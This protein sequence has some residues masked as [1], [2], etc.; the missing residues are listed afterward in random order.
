M[1]KRSEFHRVCKVREV[2]VIG[3]D[4]HGKTKSQESSQKGC[5][6]NASEGS[7]E[8]GR[9]KKGQGQSSHENAKNDVR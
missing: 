9:K 4:A 2:D 5:C 6:E 1:E 8:K 7:Y 3:G